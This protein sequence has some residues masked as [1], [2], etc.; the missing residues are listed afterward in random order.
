MA[1]YGYG[2]SVSGSRTAI[3]A[4]GG[5]APSVIVVAT[6]TNVIVTFGDT[7]EINYARDNYP[8]SV[9][10]FVNN[11]TDEI[12]FQ[13]LNFN[14]DESGIWALAQYSSGEEGGLVVKATNPS[15]NPLI[16]PTTGWTYTLGTGPTVTITAV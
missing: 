16:I 7:S 2:I 1:R 13:R 3:V 15:T 14:F 9:F 4:S 8:A 10:Y 11:P 5:A 12:S 6:T